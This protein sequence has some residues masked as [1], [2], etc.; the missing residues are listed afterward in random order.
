MSSDKKQKKP[1]YLNNPNLPTVGAEFE[2]TPEMLA[3]MQLCS[4]NVLHFAEN[5]FYIINLDEG[6]QKIKLHLY[7]K[8][9]LRMIRDNRFS[10]LLFSRQTGKALDINTKIPTPE[11][12]RLMGELKTG[13]K[14]FN[15]FGNE[16]TIKFAHPIEYNR[17]CYKITFDTGETVIADEEHLWFT[18][19]LSDRKSKRN[20]SVK[21]TKELLVKIK[22]SENS[23]YHRI[24]YAL[25]GIEYNEKDFILDPYILGLWLGDG[26]TA[27]GRIISGKRDIDDI[28][29]ILSEK[30][31]FGLHKKHDGNVNITL[32]N[33]NNSGESLHIKLR[34]LNLI[35]NKHIPDEYFYGSRQQRLELLKGLIDSDGY[36]DKRNGIATFYNKNLNLVMQVDK[37]LKSL[38]YKTTYREKEAKLNG[39]SY[40]ICGSINFKPREEVCKLSFKK[41]RLKLNF[42]TTSECRNQWHYIM[43]IEKVDSVPVRCITVDNPSGMFLFGENNIPTHNSTICTIFCLWTAIFFPDQRIIL[44]ANK[45]STAKEIFKRIR[46]AYE[47]LPN[48]LKS[49]VTYYGMESMELAN[50]SRIG[51]TTT[52]G[53]AGR[54]SAA[55]LLFIDEADWIEANLLDEFWASVYPIISSSKKSKIIMASTP[56]DTS[57]LFYKLYD[58]STRLTN[59]WKSMKIKWDEVPGRDEKWMKETMASIGD[60]NVWRREFEV[61]FDEVGESALDVEA[62]EMMKTLVTEPKYIL[63]DDC[64]NIWYPA[65][66]E[67]SYVAGVDISEGLGRDSTC[68]QIL[69]VT[70]PRNIIQVACYN[71]NKISPSEFTPKLFEILEQWGRPYV[72]IERNNCGGQV[73]DNLKRI[74]D[75]EN[76]VSWGI[77]E[78]VNRKN[79]QLGVISHTNTKYKCIQNMRHW[80]LKTKSVAINDINTV[81]E[82]KDFIRYKNGTWAAKANSHDDRVMSLG[83][84]L[85]ILSEEIVERYFEILEKDEFQ[86]PMVIKELDLGVKYLVKPDYENLNALPVY[87]GMHKETDPSLDELTSS[88]WKFLQ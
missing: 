39:K 16:C 35:G 25:N 49:P 78:A 22:N 40:G 32:K 85:M 72:L 31:D 46:M 88:G 27:G 60:A 81:L 77:K 65:S 84:A 73:V 66:D 79:M 87:I 38:G 63:E 13:D 21:T 19:T 76:I 36:I 56:R 45:E 42:N 28:L 29:Q 59:N 83:W 41:Q 34:N 70:E 82:L 53:T 43:D 44:V 58:G 71:N 18:Q 74:Y 48:W 24:P 15:E 11:G 12:I 7:Q 86:K 20:G 10:L 64:Y 30:C 47:N 37:L 8:R 5:H 9:A 4:E 61:E 68:I 17:P 23:P 1:I 2:Y 57:G 3:E 69:D 6:R 26:H 54:G 55:N 14:V 52:T 67:K 75:Y 50:G 80:M 33:L 51:I 62:F